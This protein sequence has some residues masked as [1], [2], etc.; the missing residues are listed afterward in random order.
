MESSLVAGDVQ[1]LTTLTREF[2][3]PAFVNQ[4]HP[5]Q[6]RPAGRAHLKSR[7]G[8]CQTTD[9]M[10]SRITPTLV[11]AFIGWIMCAAA[12]GISMA[13]TS[14]KTALV[15][16]AIA[17]PIIF[18]ALSISYFRR[19]E[20]YSPVVAAILFLGFVVLMDF[21]LVALVIERSLEM[22][23]SLLGTWIP[24]VEI[25]GAT[26]LTGMATTRQGQN[27]VSKSMA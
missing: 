27:P 13:F 3:V 26:Y 8:I 1:S 10:K 25:F 9:S 20:R 11:Y 15:I 19:H 24:F 7:V 16:H 23:T 2:N 6:A 22:F 5:P 17:A 18:V 14:M 12:M 21:F 4:N